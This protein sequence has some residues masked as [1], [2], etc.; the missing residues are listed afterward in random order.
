MIRTG[1]LIF[2]L[3][4]AAAPLAV[5][6]QTAIAGQNSYCTPI[7]GSSMCL[8]RTQ[9]RPNGYQCDC[10]SSTCGNHAGALQGNG[11][12]HC[13]TTPCPGSPGSN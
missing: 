3:A 10:F 9:A 5:A 8:C 2:V 12:P 7:K 6:S 11:K 4:L 1:R 13:T